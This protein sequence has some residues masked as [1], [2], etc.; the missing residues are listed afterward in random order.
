MVNPANIADGTLYRYIPLYGTANHS[1]DLAAAAG[2]AVDAGAT[3][4]DAAACGDGH[5]I[6]SELERL[7]FAEEVYEK[8]KQ[9]DDLQR[10]NSFRQTGSGATRKRPDSSI[11][12]D[13]K[14]T[15]LCRSLC[16]AI[17]EQRL[18][19]EKSPP[20][21]GTSLPPV[22][23]CMAQ[24]CID[25]IG[26]SCD[27]QSDGVLIPGNDK[28]ILSKDA[29][30]VFQ[31]LTHVL[32]EIQS[33][34]HPVAKGNCS[35]QVPR[36][37]FENSADLPPDNLCHGE[38]GFRSTTGPYDFTGLALFST[39]AFVGDDKLTAARDCWRLYPDFLRQNI[40][41]HAMSKSTIQA[42]LPPISRKRTL[43]EVMRSS[44]GDEECRES[45]RRRL[46]AACM[47]LDT[48]APLDDCAP[49][50]A[51]PVHPLALLAVLLS[52]VETT[53]KLG[54]Q[55][56]EVAPY[57]AKAKVA[58]TPEGAQIATRFSAYTFPTSKASDISNLKKE[59]LIG[60]NATLG[61]VLTHDK[62]KG[63]VSK[64]MKL[65]L[66]ACCG[67]GPRRIALRIAYVP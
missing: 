56:L 33:N 22:V 25:L 54:S 7:G 20:G 2:D 58:E 24:V 34:C 64:L 11:V 21:L 63:A 61:T 27:K 55:V 38:P 32:S 31:R 8:W 50:P 16:N 45:S 35:I 53:G 12:Q 40:T 67:E 18:P 42:V 9:L 66:V 28:C 47:G 29:F 14:L 43:I 23:A 62:D 26:L 46:T 15:G 4:G 1:P 17:G 52:D 41:T 5:D 51:P 49:K 13:D 36:P 57:L 65:S 19:K 30:A 59:R 60:R 39:L 10:I 37:P 6:R 3:A 44:G 48:A